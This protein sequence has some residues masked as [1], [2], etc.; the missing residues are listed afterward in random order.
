MR[1]IF[2][3][4]LAAVAASTSIGCATMANGSRQAVAVT[5]EPLGAHV[6]VNGKPAGTTP[7]RLDLKRRQKRTVLRVERDGFLPREIRLERTLSGWTAGNLVF[8]NPYAGQGTSS[9]PKYSTQLLTTASGFGLD[10][11]T[12][13][14]FQF[15]ATVNVA[16]EPGPR[17]PAP[18]Q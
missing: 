3:V 11:L 18:R 12:G 2:F 15:P 13:A 6:Y 4:A 1:R 16:L 17:P 5:S 7:L 14:A 9:P 10:F 8:A